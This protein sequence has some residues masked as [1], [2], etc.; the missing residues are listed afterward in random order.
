MTTTPQGG[1]PSE[2]CVVVRHSSESGSEKQGK[3]NKPQTKK[4]RFVRK[5]C[6]EHSE[7]RHMPNGY[8]PT[9]A[10][11]HDHLLR[12]AR[13]FFS[14]NSEFLFETFTSFKEFVFPLNST[15]KIP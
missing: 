14:D 6:P 1:I 11:N 8:D 15:L 9:G 7:L 12:L 5:E 2:P 3:S 13:H 4:E 10:L